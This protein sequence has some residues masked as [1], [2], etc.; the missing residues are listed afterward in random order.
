MRTATALNP[1]AVS[2][3]ETIFNHL[4]VNSPSRAHCA[5][6]KYTLSWDFVSQVILQ[7][8]A[9]TDSHTYS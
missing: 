1:R 2:P 6:L 7:S 5:E 9:D 8:F 4:K 3:E